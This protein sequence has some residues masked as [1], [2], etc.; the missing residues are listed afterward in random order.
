MGDLECESVLLLA[1]LFMLY[2][3][4]CYVCYCLTLQAVS[5]DLLKGIVWMGTLRV[6]V[7]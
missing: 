7:L 3:R 6:N 5:E 2:L 4:P 1:Y